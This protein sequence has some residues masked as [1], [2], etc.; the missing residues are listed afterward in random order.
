[1]MMAELELERWWFG[2]RCYEVCRDYQ[3]PQRRGKEVPEHAGE[4]KEVLMRV[5]SKWR[6]SSGPR[7]INASDYHI[8]SSLFLT[9]TP[10]MTRSLYGLKSNF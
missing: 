2:G 4:S 9:G 3:R 5:G 7:G 1:M 8:W 6:G 10:T